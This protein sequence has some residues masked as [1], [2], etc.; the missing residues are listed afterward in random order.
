MPTYG[1][2]LINVLERTGMAQFL[3]PSFLFLLTTAVR[4]LGTA[5]SLNYV[6]FSPTLLRVFPFRHRSQAKFDS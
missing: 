3:S 1:N 6:N 4:V 2:W 5:V